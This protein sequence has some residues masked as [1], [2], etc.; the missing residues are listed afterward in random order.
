ME[1]LSWNRLRT[2]KY[3][4]FTGFLIFLI[5]SEKE[6]YSEIQKK[7]GERSREDRY[8]TRK[9]EKKKKKKGYKKERVNKKISDLVLYVRCLLLYADTLQ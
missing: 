6:I 8:T 1:E 9:F 7:G 5:I 4:V 2:Q 3:E